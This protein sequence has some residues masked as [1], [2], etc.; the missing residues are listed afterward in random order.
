MDRG[1][2]AASAD[3]GRYDL[4]GPGRRPRC[5][6]VGRRLHPSVARIGATTRE[7]AALGRSA[8]VAARRRPAS[9]GR[10]PLTHGLWAGASRRTVLRVDD[11][12]DEPQE[13][14]VDFVL[15][16]APAAPPQP[17]DA[18]GRARTALSEDVVARVR[19]IGQR[20][21]RAFTVPWRWRDPR[22][23]DDHDV[24]YAA[25]QLCDL[26]GR[27]TPDIELGDRRA[28]AASSAVHT[29]L[30]AIA[31]ADLMSLDD[32]T[33]LT[34]PL[35]RLVDLDLASRHASLRPAGAPESGPL[36]A[37]GARRRSASRP[38]A[39]APHPR[40]PCHRR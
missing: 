34:D 38:R 7:R 30:T 24:S 22:T 27:R 3:V 5:R 31:V 26:H 12:D 8:S 35:S 33:Y 36:C 19:G 20:R 23:G 11:H 39:V 9:P 40:P 1:A 17:D 4:D 32:F 25:M 2:A 37:G 15:D 6:R 18:A 28:E 14:F 21:R 29:G 10:V 16:L 13:C